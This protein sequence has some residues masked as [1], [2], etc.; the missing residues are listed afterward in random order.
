MTGVRWEHKHLQPCQV[1]QKGIAVD[2]HEPGWVG[3]PWPTWKPGPLFLNGGQCFMII[4]TYSQ[5]LTASTASAALARKGDGLFRHL[6]TGNV[7]VAV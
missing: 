5:M 6:P 4:T 7:F 3:G 1:S 2:P